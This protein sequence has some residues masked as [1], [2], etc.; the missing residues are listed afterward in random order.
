ME[1]G[2][3]NCN[4]CVRYSHQRIAIGTGRH[5]NKRVTRDHPC[6][7]IVVIGQNTEKSPGDRRRLVVT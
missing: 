2:I 7:S 1:H 5:G 6:T 3:D 4:Y